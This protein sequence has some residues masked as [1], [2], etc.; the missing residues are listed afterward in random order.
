MKKNGYTLLELITTIALISIVAIIIVP[1]INSAIKTSRADQLEEV[2]E[3]VKNA[4]EVFLNNNCG[5]EAYNKLINDGK[6]RV[7]LST[8]SSCGLIDEKIYNPMNEEYFDIENEYVDI[9][10]DEVGMRDYK[11]SF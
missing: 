10:I 4:S 8:I 3:E 11:L 2:R 9:S 7:Y 6:I 1:K 5:K